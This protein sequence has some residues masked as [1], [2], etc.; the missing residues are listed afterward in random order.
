VEVDESEPEPEVSPHATPVPTAMPTPSATTKAALRP[1][2]AAALIAGLIR[3]RPCRETGHRCGALPAA[4][5]SL[6]TRSAVSQTSRRSRGICG[7]NSS[8]CRSS[9]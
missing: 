8:T 5:V 7:P 3:C 4:A 6:L 2:C 1:T 9:R